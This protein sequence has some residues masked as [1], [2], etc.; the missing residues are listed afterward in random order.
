LV[1]ASGQSDA[2]YLQIFETVRV[3][4]VHI[5]SS[6]LAQLSELLQEGPWHVPRDGGGESGRPSEHDQ[7]KKKKKNDENY[8][9]KLVKRRHNSHV[10]REG[11][12]SDKAYYTYY[13]HH[14]SSR[15]SQWSFHEYQHGVPRL[16]KEKFNARAKGGRRTYS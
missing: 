16:W 11:G 1:L 3:R 15:H 9:A 8:R 13:S 4:H 2:R 10:H 12:V 14:P 5:P 6:S 7:K